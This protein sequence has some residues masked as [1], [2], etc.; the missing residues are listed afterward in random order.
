MEF[1]TI[2]Q[3]LNKWNGA[4]ILPS[5]I[6]LSFFFLLWNAQHPSGL[7]ANSWHL[8]IIFIS[9]ILS[10]IL[11]PLP[12]GAISIIAV[13]VTILTNTLPMAQVLSSFSSGIVWL[14]VSAF[15]LARGFI[16][17]GLGS[18]I[19][20]CFIVVLGKNTLGLAY[21]LT[22]AELIFAP[23][24]PSNTARGAGIIYPIILGLNK[25]YN[26]SPHNKTHKKLG[27]Y[28]I[29]L[30]FQI[31]VI[32]SAMFLTATAGNPLVV[33]IAADQG[34][35]LTWNIWALACIVPGVINLILIPIIMFIVNPPEIKDT[36]RAPSFALKKLKE[37]GPMK[38]DE[39][40]MMIV[41]IILLTLWILGTKLG[42]DA[43]AAALLGLCLLLICGVLKWSDVIKEKSA[44]DTFIWMAVLIM[45]STQLSKHGITSWFGN[46]INSMVTDM[47]WSYVLIFICIV[48]LYSHYL[49]ASMTAHIS[50]LFGTFLAVC[51]SSGAPPLISVL[52]LGVIS[53]LC[54]GI[55]HYGTGSAPVYFGSEYNTI[56]DWW[57][58]GFIASVANL[59]I[60]I[61]FGG[62]WW[63][64]LNY[65]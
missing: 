34:V 50:A 37:L 18:R 41:F 32:T 58:L 6:V 42:V 65:W 61:I 47:R 30:L 16:K 29:Q 20:Y 60:W 7:N 9:T 1:K 49:F 39:V 27:S 38:L 26:S 22:F 23:G 10:L 28:L 14:I 24:T 11:K 2:K 51:L 35:E 36:P 52:I 33:S 13:T 17:T 63:K 31:N 4:N 21:G 19:A 45:L 46:Y 56:S 8:F 54:A 12:M 3:S 57:K 62:I 15:L 53:S 44:W 43:T 25:E 48:Y 64:I 55:T 59:I 5:I 40:I